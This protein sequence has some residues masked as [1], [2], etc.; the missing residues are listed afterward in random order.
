MEDIIE[1]QKAEAIKVSEVRETFAQIYHKYN[2]DN[3]Y[4]RYMIGTCIKMTGKCRRISRSKFI[5]YVFEVIQDDGLY[6][7]EGDFFRDILK[8]VDGK[9]CI[10]EIDDDIELLVKCKSMLPYYEVDA[11]DKYNYY[12]E[13]YNL[14]P[15]SYY[16]VYDA[17]DKLKYYKIELKFNLAPK[18]VKLMII[19]YGVRYALR[20]LGVRIT[21]KKQMRLIRNV[22]SRV[23]MD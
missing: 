15:R 4:D 20:K 2:L 16:D 11:I 12:R 8:K 14:T 7:E 19:T 3:I 10:K 22:I 21:K 17:I 5:K 6:K 13:R 9:R 1:R 18:D 23:R